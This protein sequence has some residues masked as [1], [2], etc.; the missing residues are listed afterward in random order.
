MGL[1]NFCGGTRGKITGMERVGG[2]GMEEEGLEEEL[3][4]LQA[5]P[6]DLVVV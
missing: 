1:L 4:D 3:M 2:K 5:I 6:S